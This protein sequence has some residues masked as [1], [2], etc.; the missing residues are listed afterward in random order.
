M[1]KE[2]LKDALIVVNIGALISIFIANI[3]ILLFGDYSYKD[4]V[5]SETIFIPI[6]NIISYVTCKIESR[7]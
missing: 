3:L 6:I 7:K 5:I 4:V 1:N 2:I